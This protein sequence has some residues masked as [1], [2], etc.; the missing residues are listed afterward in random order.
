MLLTSFTGI[1]CTAYQFGKASVAED[2]LKEIPRDKKDVLETEGKA[3]T[4]HGRYYVNGTFVDE[5]G[6]IWDYATTEIDSQSV[7]DAMPVYAIF[8]DNYTVPIE[9]DEIRKICID[10]YTQLMEEGK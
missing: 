4:L 7:Y 2:L 6:N 3:Y 1:T 5:E 8:W 9:D 10:Y